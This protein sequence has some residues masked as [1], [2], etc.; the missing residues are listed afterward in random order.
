VGIVNETEAFFAAKDIPIILPWRTEEGLPSFA[1]PCR[2]GDDTTEQDRF[3]SL[4]PF[5]AKPTPPPNPPAPIVASLARMLARLHVAG[6]GQGTGQEGPVVGWNRTQF[7]LEAGRAMELARER[8]H[9]T[10]AQ[11]F[12]AILEKKKAWVRSA[13][14]SYVLQ[15]EHA[16]LLH[17][18]FQGQNTFLNTQTM[19]ISHVFDLEKAG[20]GDY[21]YEVARC[22]LVTCFEEGY[23][24]S[25]FTRGNVFIRAYREV[26]HE[27][28]LDDFRRGLLVFLHDRARMTWVENSYLIKEERKYL[29]RLSLMEE[30]F[31]YFARGESAVDEMCDR[32]FA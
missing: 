29:P 25:A 28:S 15:P 24:E 20:I 18:D 13:P 7:E 5:V 14:D 16:T 17:N 21:A 1:I 8:P 11:R 6:R 9:D 12:R 10:F 27:F 32:L 2:F 30:R 26:A 3:A 19:D 22:L 31:A 23:N 4:Y